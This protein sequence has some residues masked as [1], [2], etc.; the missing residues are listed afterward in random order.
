MFS[1]NGATDLDYRKLL[2]FDRAEMSQ[3]LLDFSFRP[4][5]AQELDDS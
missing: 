4:N 5:V 1:D 2:G 3:V